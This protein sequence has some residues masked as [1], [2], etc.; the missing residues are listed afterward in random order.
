MYMQQKKPQNPM[1]VEPVPRLL[2]RIGAPIVV[3]M[4]LQA[5]YNVV[6][7][8]CAI[9]NRAGTSSVRSMPLACPP[10]SRRRC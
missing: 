1:A 8:A 7:S 5:A 9:G 2:A 3:S 6:D 4:I 10:L